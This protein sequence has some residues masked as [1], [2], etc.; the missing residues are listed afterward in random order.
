MKKEMELVKKK[1]KKKLNR[2]FLS[3]Y[4]SS[5]NFSFLLLNHSLTK[6]NKTFVKSKQKP[7]CPYLQINDRLSKI[8]HFNLFVAVVSLEQRVIFFRHKLVSDSHEQRNCGA[9][10]AHISQPNARVRQNGFKQINHNASEVNV[11]D[12]NQVKVTE[13][14][15]LGREA[16]DLWKQTKPKF[17][18]KN[19]LD[20]HSSLPFQM[21]RRH[22]ANA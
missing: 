6:T 11:D 17:S 12:D 13:L 4:L 22:L 19:L 18:L 21:H 14:L 9:F 15:E 10:C 5:R 16:N 2:K 8:V 20:E 7:P 1:K 3:P